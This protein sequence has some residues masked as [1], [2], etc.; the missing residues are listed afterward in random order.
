MASNEPTA[1][2]SARLA[3]GTSHGRLVSMLFALFR[4]S[5]FL[6]RCVTLRLSAPNT[7]TKR[8]FAILFRHGR[9]SM[10]C[11][12]LTMNAGPIEQGVG[13]VTIRSADVSAHSKMPG[14][15]CARWWREACVETSFSAAR[16]KARR[17]Q[18]NFSE[19]VDLAVVS[20]P[21]ILH[22][23]AYA[24]SLPRCSGSIQC[25]IRCTR[26][27]STLTINGERD[28]PGWL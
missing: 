8:L 28:A 16:D 26:L 24:R 23:S 18:C 5:V 15:S 11:R 2:I 25:S 4:R 12:D 3:C 17:L 6:S 22:S 21:A 7:A 13:P 20:L 27:G 19:H 1:L 14:L 9:I 10:S